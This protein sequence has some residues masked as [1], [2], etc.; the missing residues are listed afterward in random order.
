MNHCRLV[1]WNSGDWKQETCDD[2][3][4]NYQRY[5]HFYKS[6]LVCR[7]KAVI[8]EIT[9]NVSERSGKQKASMERREFKAYSEFY[10]Q[11]HFHSKSS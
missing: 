2:S 10:H 6:Y 3:P 7:N 9:F 4:S 8:G 5:L 11:D 1:M